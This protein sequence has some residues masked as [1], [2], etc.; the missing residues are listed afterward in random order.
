MLALVP[1]PASPSFYLSD[2]FETDVSREFSNYQRIPCTL[3]STEKHL[4][5]FKPR[6]YSNTKALKLALVLAFSSLLATATSKNRSKVLLLGIIMYLELW[7]YIVV[8]HTC[9]PVPLPELLQ[10]SSLLSCS[11]VPQALM[12]ISARASPAANM[13]RCCFAG[14][15]ERSKEGLTWIRLHRK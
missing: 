5:V 9:K 1:P 4:A 2:F 3:C 10:L 11:F 15:Q 7:P 14:G 6:L 13:S 8:S 12:N